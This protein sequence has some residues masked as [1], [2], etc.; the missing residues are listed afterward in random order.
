MNVS[1]CSI[2]LSI[3]MYIVK[4]FAY[5]FGCRSCLLIKV[6]VFHSHRFPKML[7]DFALS[8]CL[9]ARN[10]YL[11]ACGANSDSECLPC[12]LWWEERRLHMGVEQRMQSVSFCVCRWVPLLEISDQLLGLLPCLVGSSLHHYWIIY[13]DVDGSHC[14]PYCRSYYSANFSSYHSPLHI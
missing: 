6:G 9:S 5:V 12:W 11:P 3:N 8:V 13:L 7:G 10:L 1:S 14:Q 2:P 4:L